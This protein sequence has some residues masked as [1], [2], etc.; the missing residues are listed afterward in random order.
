MLS[1]NVKHRQEN[2]KNIRNGWRR[3]SR[4]E[5]LARGPEREGDLPSITQQ[6]RVRAWKTAW[7]WLQDLSPGATTSEMLR[8]R[9]E[10]SRVKQL[11]FSC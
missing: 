5:Y 3:G 2:K 8:A 6:V 10:V 9:H 1:Q 11:L 4:T 7:V